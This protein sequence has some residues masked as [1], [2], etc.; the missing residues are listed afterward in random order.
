MKQKIHSTSQ[1]KSAEPGVK[2]DLV[3]RRQE[4]AQLIGH[5]IARIW[6]KNQHPADF[7]ARDAT[8]SADKPI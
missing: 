5:L 2:N 4:L 8:G 6:L 7:D 3:D 1:V